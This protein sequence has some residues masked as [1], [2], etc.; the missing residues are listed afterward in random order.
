[1]DLINAARNGDLSAVK[2]GIKRGEDVNSEEVV[3]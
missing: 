2:A 3:I 1:M